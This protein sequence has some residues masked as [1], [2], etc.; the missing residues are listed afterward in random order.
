MSNVAIL[1][2]AA[3]PA[4]YD[5]KALALIK[6]TVAADCNDDEFGMFIHMARALR[7]DP[8]RRQIYAFVFSKADPKKRRMSII[9][10]ID[11][12]RAIAEKTGNYRPDEEE[13]TYELDP[14]SKG[15]NNPAGLVK[16]TV[17]VWKYAHEDWHK[18]TASACKR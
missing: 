11:G 4:T 13:P 10:A 15:P 9:T 3:V 5:A 12:F 14:A 1:R 7:L 6:R 17:R 16:A 18:V 2:P 8:L